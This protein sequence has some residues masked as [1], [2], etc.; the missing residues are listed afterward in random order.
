MKTYVKNIL[1]YLVALLGL[2][3][4]IAMFS[5]PLE[6]YDGVKGIWYAYKVKAYTGE[7]ANNVKLYHGS[8]VPL[9]GFITPLICGLVLIIESFQPSWGKKSSIINTIM[10]VLF[11]FSAILVLL[12]KELFLNANELGEYLKIRNGT[13]PVFSAIC[14]AIAGLIL[15]FVTYFPSK[16]Q[17]EYIQK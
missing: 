11:F 5:T 1:C 6:T 10:V 13:G 17:M 14:S 12:T 7:T 8:A 16:S 2:L 9:I 15:L 3:A 4:F